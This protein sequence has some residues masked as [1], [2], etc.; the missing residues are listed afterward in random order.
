MIKKL[1]TSFLALCVALPVMAQSSASSDM[2]GPKRGDFQVSLN[3]GS[4]K[5]LNEALF[6]SNSILPSY[7]GSS[8]GLNPGGTNQ[9][10]DPSIYLNLGS[11]NDNSLV[12]I[13][14]I[15]GAYFITDRI[16]INALFS[17]DISSTPQKDYVEGE[18]VNSDGSYDPLDIPSQL[19]VEGRVSNKFMSAVGAN[20]YFNTNSSRIDLYAGLS[21]GFNFANLE[22]R[23]P[24]AYDESDPEND[25]ALYSNYLR[26][27]KIQTIGVHTV[28]GIE[29]AL[30]E[31][32][33][34]GFEISPISYQNS[35]LT[36]STQNSANYNVIHNYVKILS[37]PTLKFGFRF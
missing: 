1:V 12:N 3:L 21:F 16:Q 33:F 22:T 4:G 20:Y 6:D 11:F 7:N 24:Y 2:L 23:M 8:V 35:L 36:I 19:Y 18:S 25:A 31:G 34:L 27:G 5:F 10:S 32:L 26:G 29:Y 28:A 14:G 9:S 17:M 15:Q 13:A 30:A 37:F